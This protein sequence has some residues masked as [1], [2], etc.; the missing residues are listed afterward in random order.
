M[1]VTIIT[2]QIGNLV[3]TVT[4]HE[5]SKKGKGVEAGIRMGPGQKAHFVEVDDALGKITNGIEFHE[6]I[7][8]YIPRS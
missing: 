5:L 3:G 8:A 1:K 7:R 2:D 6:K 4:G